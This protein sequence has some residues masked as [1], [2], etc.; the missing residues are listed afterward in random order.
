MNQDLT[1]CF[2]GLVL[3]ERMAEVRRQMDRVVRK[4]LK[5]GVTFTFDQG[6]VELHPTRVAGEV[7]HLPYQLLTVRSDFN[8]LVHGGNEDARLLARVEFVRDTRDGERTAPVRV[9]VPG[10]DLDSYTL[11]ELDYHQCDHCETRRFRTVSY[12]V[13]DGV[14]VLQVGST[15]MNEYVGYDV[16]AVLRVF[17]QFTEVAQEL[18]DPT[19]ESAML[20]TVSATA[21]AWVDGSEVMGVA[22]DCMKRFG[23]VSR[24]MAETEYSTSTV[25][26]VKRVVMGLNVSP[27]DTSP[28]EYVEFTRK[29]VQWMDDEMTKDGEFTVNTYNASLTRVDG[30]PFYSATTLHFGVMAVLLYV[31]AQEA[32]REQRDGKNEHF[33]DVKERVS[34]RV[35][36]ASYRQ[37]AGYYGDTH[38]YNLRDEEGRAV[39]WFASSYQQWL[40]DAQSPVDVVGTVK[41]HKEYRGT[42]QTVLTRVK[43]VKATA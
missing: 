36:M 9:S 27:F 22:M 38:V 19:K 14:K 13:W 5:C 24:R 15:C 10:V 43:Q 18:S 33:G 6:D 16:S 21:A 17:N 29:V 3:A 39:V 11:P 2:K 25:E 40:N 41:Q 4:G 12:L 8:R 20:D 32:K 34:A 1:V 31:R 37:T 7:F 30:V 28:E 42:K 26:S 23:F 35:T